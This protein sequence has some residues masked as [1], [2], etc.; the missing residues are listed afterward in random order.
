MIA[1]LLCI[2]EM[3]LKKFKLVSSSAENNYAVQEKNYK[4]RKRLKGSVCDGQC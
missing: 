3:G 1:S 2:S 4:L